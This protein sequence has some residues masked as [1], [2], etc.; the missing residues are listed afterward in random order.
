M[1]TFC[2]CFCPLGDECGRGGKRL[3]KAIEE[4]DARDK[5]KAHLRDSSHHYGKHSEDDIEM[6]ANAADLMPEEGWDE[7]KGKCKSK[8]SEPYGGKGKGKGKWA[9][10]QSWESA[11]A[12]SSSS[13]L[14][15]VQIR[16]ADK[17]K[18]DL[19]A[20]VARCEAAARQAGRM[21]RSAAVAFESE[22]AVLHECMESIGD[23]LG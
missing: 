3:G 9:E 2:V 15:R 10:W 4:S 22:A 19:M 23:M 16:L 14:A 11:P 6:L 21:A 7:E 12:S 17:K 18:E 8:R 20:A 5:I 1:P 13:A